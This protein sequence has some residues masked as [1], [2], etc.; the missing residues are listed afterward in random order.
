M[1]QKYVDESWDFR[2]ENTKGF[3]HCFHNYPAMMIPQVANRLISKYGSNAGLL[4]DPYCGTGTSLVEANLKN[5][6]AVGTDLNPLAR[7][8]AKAKTTLIDK[9]H[10]DL[11]LKDFND[12]I[13]RFRFGIDKSDSVMLPNFKN[14]DYWFTKS[15][16][17]KLAVIKKI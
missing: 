5:I 7:L 13:F 10:L 9:Q 4:F 6:N 3:T 14:I 1:G 12:K 17:Q 8:I 11:L 15:V 2:T 16:Q